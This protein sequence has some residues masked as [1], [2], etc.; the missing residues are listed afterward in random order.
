MVP[1]R[2]FLRGSPGWVRSSLDLTLLIDAEHDRVF[3]RIQIEPD[4]V[5]QLFDEA[6]IVGEFE[7][8]DPVRLQLMCSPD[9][10]HGVWADTHGLGHGSAATSGVTSTSRSCWTACTTSTACSTPR[11][12]PSCG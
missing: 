3:G 5:G 6:R 4:H 12:A 8:G 9:P 1:Q 11:A 7:A 2:P 10:V